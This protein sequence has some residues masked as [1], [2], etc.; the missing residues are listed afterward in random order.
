MTPH[1]WKIK[2]EG[3]ENLKKYDSLEVTISIEIDL[4]KRIK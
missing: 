4:L 3:I 2:P 1:Y